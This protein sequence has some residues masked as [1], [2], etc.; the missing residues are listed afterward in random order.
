MNDYFYGWYFRCQGK[1]GCVAVIPAV[2]FSSGKS[3]CSIQIITKYESL[4]KEFPISQFRFNRKRKLMQIGE[5][6]FSTRGIRLNFEANL[7]EER[8]DIQIS[9]CGQMI[10]RCVSVRGVMCFGVFSELQYDIMG[11]FAWVPGMECKHK[12]YSMKH[13]V[14]GYIRLNDQKIVFQNDLGYMEG[15]NG[16]SFPEKYIPVSVC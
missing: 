11:P 13:T 9:R 16:T 15:D 2:H 14:N 5:S 7:T 1:D 12:V 4:Y 6:L 8:A 10:P 3:S